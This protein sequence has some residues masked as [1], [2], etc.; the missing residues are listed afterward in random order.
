MKYL[1]NLFERSK[2]QWKN[3]AYFPSCRKVYFLEII[4]GS[5]MTAT[6]QTNYDFVE[7]DAFLLIDLPS[8]I[9]SKNELQLKYFKNTH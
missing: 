6:R 2:I 5:H 7:Y 1:K 9:Q 8:S 4:Y 3:K